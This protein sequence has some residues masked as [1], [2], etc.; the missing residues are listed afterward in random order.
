M[1]KAILIILG[2]VVVLL[3][4]AMILP[5]IYKDEIK[6]KVDKEIV[7]RVDAKVYYQDFD[8]S[9]FRHFPNIT[10]TLDRFGVAGRGVFRGDTLIS[11]NSFEVTVNIMSVIGGDKIKIKAL[12]LENPRIKVKVLKDGKAN[13]DIYIP[14]TTEVS[15]SVDTTKS[16]FALQVD[17]WSIKNGYVVYDDR[18][19]PL[20]AKIINLNHT[21]SGDIN[22]DIY[23]L[24]TRTTIDSLTVAYDGTEY[25]HK[26][27]LEADMTLNMNMPQSKYTFKEN[28]VKLNDFAFGFDGYVALPDTVN[29]NLDLTFKA[30]ENTF[31]SLLSLVPGVYTKDF[32]DLTAEGNV[33]FDGFAKGTYND[34]Q[35][36]GF[37]LNV[38]VKEGQMKYT[39]LPTA[40]KNINVDMKVN[41]PDGNL[42]NTVVDIKKFHADF[43][44]NPVDGRV[45]LKGLTNYDIDANILARLNLGELTQMFP[46]EGLTLKGLYNLD[47]KAKGVYSDSLKKMPAVNAVM[48]L[49]N[50]YVK[51]KDF[52]A[53]IEQLNFN[54]TVNNA[55]G[56]MAD[57]KINVSNF[58]MLLEGEPLT[59]NAYIEN[60]D[61]YTWDLNAKGGIDLTKL[62]KIYPLEG[63][64]LTGRVQGNIETKGK[65][66]DVEAER[67]DQ[68]P[69]SGAVQISNLTYTSTDLPQGMK[70]S[71]A[72]MNFTPQQINITSFDGSLGKSDVSV[73][74]SLT[75]YIK[76]I[77]RENETI[78]GNMSFRSQQFDVNEWMTDDP[79][80]PKTTEE[81]PL[82][83]I[84]VPKTIDFTLVS[85][86]NKVLYDNM[87]LD[88]LNGTIIVRDGA[89]RMEKLNFNSLGG[90]FIANGVYDSKD[91]AKPS[92]DFD[93]N[94]AGVAVQEAYKTFN[95]VKAL[96]PMAQ[97]IQGDFSTDFKIGGRLGQDMMPLYPTLTGGGIIKLAQAII[98]DAPVLTSLASVTRLKDLT[99]AQLRDIILKAE[100][101]DGRIYFQPFD[102]QVSN[103]KMNVGGSNGIDGSLDYKVKMDIPAGVIGAQV[104]NA[105]ASL[106]GKAVQNAETITLNLNVGGTATNPKI[107]LAGSSTSG[108]I[109]E[110]AKE[111]VK[112]RVTAEVARA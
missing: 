14:D 22:Q 57:T 61:N 72:S 98:K 26:K 88:N 1:K 40:V 69:T 63:M 46:M 15:P 60:L 34:K 77:F 70:I 16:E 100:V 73:T 20:Y 51:S 33:A 102:V 87:T 75:N 96:M 48:S 36:P 53:P 5:V 4:A 56:Q 59:A 32:K 82:S 17:Q 9:I 28:T 76:Y 24:A 42:E 94:I 81:E 92:F 66:S 12:D 29:T 74:G 18:T 67:Y 58:R 89:V 109:A 83:V 86:I 110:T 8:V 19:L 10:A 65:M 101:K 93:L 13:Y 71:K 25:L 31:K 38:Q 111:A 107:G 84:E 103:Y 97:Y 108:S 52:P 90:N 2:I 80:A 105:L 21:G 43:G 50:G 62:T 64:T 68:L 106:T 45:W 3:G 27:R 54:A 11:A 35:M 79:N 91:I 6:A 37:G 39:D 41:N 7:K 30:K 44:K 85:S 104:N 47:L 112:E 55:T 99:P 23:D 78:R 49:A 95:T